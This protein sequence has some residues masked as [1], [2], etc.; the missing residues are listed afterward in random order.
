MTINI[1]DEMLDEIDKVADEMFCS[2][3]VA[4]R[5]LYRQWLSDSTSPCIKVN[6]SASDEHPPDPAR[7]PV[8]DDRKKKKEDLGSSE[9]TERGIAVLL[10][11]LP[12]F[13]A[14]LAKTSSP[15]KFAS[16]LL[17]GFPGVP[18]ESELHRASGW[19]EN[20]PTR[21]KKQLGA[22]LLSWMGNHG[23]GQQSMFPA[24]E[25]TAQKQA[26]QQDYTPPEG[27]K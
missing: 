20:H 1:P 8:H 25:S 13:G 26:K 6:H 5:F 27:W 7:A 19:L 17:S 9:C 18:V 2:R 15:A 11:Q 16:Q 3:S 4:V 10:E 21:R 24:K 12:W 23:K 14:A 22:F